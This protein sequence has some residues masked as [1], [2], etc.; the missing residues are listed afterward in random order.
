MTRRDAEGALIDRPME[1]GTEIRRVGQNGIVYR[2]DFSAVDV[3]TGETRWTRSDAD[4]IPMT[5]TPDG[6]ATLLDLSSQQLHEIDGRGA[7]VGSQPFLLDSAAVY[8]FGQWLGHSFSGLA[9][10]TGQISDATRWTT[11]G[12]RQRQLQLRTPGVGIFAKSHAVLEPITFQH[13]SIR[14]TPT[15]QD[16]WKDLKPAD[17][18]NR[19]EF[20]NYFMTIGAGTAQG[21]SSIFCTGALTKGI[22]RNRDVAEQP[23]NFEQL[24]VGPLEETRLINDLYVYFDNYRNDL[25]YACVPEMNPG[26]YNSNSFA[27]GL[28]RKARAPLPLFPT[29]GTIP[30]GWATPVPPE[31]F[32]P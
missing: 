27:S 5:A 16:F 4:W 8:E 31:K 13:V 19:D 10:H 1:L 7:V 11:F 3:I 24:P 28:L 32:D 20:G 17:F 25:P 23:V 15:F 30:P 9:A 2:G 26:Q 6:G 21:D 29:R 18:V 14:I 22:N 12:N